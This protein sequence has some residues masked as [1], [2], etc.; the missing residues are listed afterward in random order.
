MANLGLENGDAVAPWV[1]TMS[2]TVGDD[3]IDGLGHAS[4]ITYVR[5]IQD[6]AIAHSTARGF[7]LEA[8]RQIGGVFI[9]RRHEIDYMRPVVRGDRLTLRTRID[10]AMAAKC[11]RSTEIAVE[12]NGVVAARA[13]TTWGFIDLAT[14]RPTRI[15]EAIRAAFGMPRVGLAALEQGDAT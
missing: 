13:V 4:N 5:W 7:D 3:D 1:F 6:V 15:P 2:I 10:T 11:K 14:G 8:Y 9:V 12:S